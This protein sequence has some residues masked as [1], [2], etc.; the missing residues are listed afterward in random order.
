MSTSTP[1]S[2]P[3]DTPLPEIF[4]NFILGYGSATAQKVWTSKVFEKIFGQLLKLRYKGSVIYLC[5]FDLWKGT[6]VK[7]IK[8]LTYCHCSGKK[9]Q[10]CSCVKCG[11]PLPNNEKEIQKHL[12][13]RCFGRFATSYEEGIIMLLRAIGLGDSDINAIFDSFKNRS[14]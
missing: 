6:L 9:Q 13:E 7:L 4:C 3:S 8:H 14:S 11:C 10:Y 2:P 12:Q 5:P 1:S